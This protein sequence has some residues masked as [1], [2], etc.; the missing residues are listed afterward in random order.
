MSGQIQG[1][2]FK[3]LLSRLLAGDLL[4]PELHAR[5]TAMDEDAWYPWPDFTEMVNRVAGKLRSYA[6]RSVGAGLME[7]SKPVFA[8]Q[9]FTSTDIMYARWEELMSANV[10]DLPPEDGAY[11]V[12]FEPGRLV[13]D[14]SAVQPAALCE[15]YL[16]GAARIFGSTIRSFEQEDVQ[17]DGHPFTRFTVVYRSSDTL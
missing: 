12:S 10:R 15:G 9:G 4:F 7:D 1:A 6:V 8:S 5:V 2:F 14:Y 3:V 17:R 13:I 16:R 11:V